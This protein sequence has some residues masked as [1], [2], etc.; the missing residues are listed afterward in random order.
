MLS[1]KG[2]GDKKEVEKDI[3]SGDIC[4]LEKPLPVMSPIS[5]EVDG[6]LLDNRK[7]EW[8][9][10]FART[11]SFCFVLTHELSQIYFSDFILHPT[12]EKVSK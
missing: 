5:L 2:W 9:P 12:G 1:N 4:L 7:S 10:C 8:I 3:Q 11:H 6:H